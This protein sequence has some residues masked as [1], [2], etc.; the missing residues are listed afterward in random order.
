MFPKEP[1]AWAMLLLPLIISLGVAGFNPPGVG[2]SGAAIALFCARSPLE[3]L[4]RG[5]GAG[6]IR[7]AGVYAFCLLTF[8]A[9]LLVFYRLWLLLPLGAAAL[10]LLGCYLL[11]VRWRRER[12]G[13]G[14]LVLIGGLALGGVGAYY[15][16]TGRM[17]SLALT[18][19]LMSFLYSGSGVFF[20]RMMVRRPARGQLPLARS[21][22]LG[23]GM[24]LYLAGVGVAVGG[25]AWFGQMPPLAPLSFLPLA[26]KALT[27]ML[28]FRGKAPIR[29]LGFMEV[30]HA[31]LFTLLLV[32]SF[33]W[34][35]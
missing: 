6:A 22:S 2:F 15:A 29:L 16:A 7:W 18:L 3:A 33:R 5:R 32:G 27:G 31:A 34:W 9:G 21:L 14:E 25:L 35:G 20:V 11:L 4:V 8:T 30:G 10:G 26:L 13:W 24:L 23:R 19:G 12:T 1:G 17:G 28:L